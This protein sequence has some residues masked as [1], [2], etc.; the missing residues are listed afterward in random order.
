[1]LSCKLFNPLPGNGVAIGSQGHFGSR[2]QPIPLATMKPRYCFQSSK[3]SPTVAAMCFSVS[4]LPAMMS[5]G[6]ASK[7][8]TERQRVW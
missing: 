6:F 1:M 7:V 2:I 8:E 4:I 5:I 3:G